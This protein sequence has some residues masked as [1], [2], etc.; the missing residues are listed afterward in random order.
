MA[1]FVRSLSLQGQRLRVLSRATSLRPL[2]VPL[3]PHRV[4]ISTSKKNKDVG[5]VVEPMEKS[6]ELKRLTE[7]FGDIDKNK[8]ENWTSYGYA[9]GDRDTDW[10]QHH[11]M[12]FLVIT[13][14]FCGCLFV[15][16]YMPD[17]MLHDWAQRE[18][19]L[20]LERR[21]RLGLPLV[22]PEYAKIDPSDLPSDEELG[23]AEIII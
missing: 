19:F 3:L 2:M 11:L 8:E 20:E 12:M 7:H 5:A 10:F 15:G 4:L 18:A 17:Y 14:A 13:V 22:D 9:P 6:A 23:D 21:E 1:A 16:A